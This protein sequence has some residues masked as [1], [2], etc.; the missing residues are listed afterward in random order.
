MTPEAL[1]EAL[2]AAMPHPGGGS[3]LEYEEALE[4]ATKALAAAQELEYGWAG[5]VL[6]MKFPSRE[7][8]EEYMGNPRRFVR[9]KAGP[10]REAPEEETH[11]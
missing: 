2:C 9:A 8:A 7:D 4:A 5:D 11:G 3:R 10:W 1:A 6:G